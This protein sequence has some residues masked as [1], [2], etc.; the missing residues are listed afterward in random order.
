MNIVKIGYTY[1]SPSRLSTLQVAEL[2]VKHYYFTQFPYQEEQ[3]LHNKY[4]NKH[5]RGE[6]YLLN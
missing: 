2:I 4:K 3:F 5:I 1:N 6:W